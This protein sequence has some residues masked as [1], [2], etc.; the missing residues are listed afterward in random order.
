M[1][2][3]ISSLSLF[4]LLLLFAAPQLSFAQ[5][6]SGTLSA[7]VSTDP[8]FEGLYKYTLTL[9]WD[10]PQFALSHPDLF[11]GLDA[12][13][14]VCDPSVA[15]F[16]VPGGHSTSSEDGEVCEND[17]FGEYVC[18]GDPALPGTLNGP[19]VKWDPDETVCTPGTVGSGVF[20]FYS[21]LPPAASLTHTDFIALKHDTEIC[22][23]DIVG[24]L[25]ICDC[26]VDVVETSLGKVKA[27][28]QPDDEE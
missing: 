13:E 1:R 28:F 9:D 7:E 21:P 4:V 17:Y 8:G 24:T 6:T 22:Y 2:R 5:C 10:L 18:T 3:S 12:C 16:A 15:Q 20:C 27:D 26:T 11:I 14:C 19:A 23:G 25:P